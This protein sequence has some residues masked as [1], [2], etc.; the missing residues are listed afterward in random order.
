MTEIDAIINAVEF[1]LHE[2]VDGTCCILNGDNEA[3]FTS[4]DY[5]HAL[6]VLET[7]FLT[8]AQVEALQLHHEVM[9]EL[10]AEDQANRALSCDHYAGF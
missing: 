3:V 8:A 2:S 4:S 6:R 5:C 10:Q 7:E 9:D 1:R